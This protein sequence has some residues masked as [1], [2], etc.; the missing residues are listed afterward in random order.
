MSSPIFQ[1]LYLSSARPEL[2]EEALLQILAE[3]Q[4]RNA[5]REVTGLLLH[6][7]GSIIQ[8][9]EGTE[10]TVEALFSKIERDPRHHNVSVLFRRFVEQR[11]FPE[12]KMGFKR[13][14]PKQLAAELPG[15]SDIV[16]NR[17]LPKATLD[18]LSKHVSV[19]L[20]TFARSTRLE[21]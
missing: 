6:S 7:D 9:I 16:E 19:F 5:A 2:T 21:D 15:F 13:A 4:Q 3:S 12:Y 10:S 17:K 14:S 18:G 11:D 8:I 20:K 1:L